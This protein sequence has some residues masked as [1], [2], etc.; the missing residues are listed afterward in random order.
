MTQGKMAAPSRIAPGIE[1]EDYYQAVRYKLLLIC[2]VGVCAYLNSL[3]GVFVLD[4]RSRIIDNPVIREL[5]RPAAV[6]LSPQRLVILS[7]Q[8]NYALTQFRPAGYHLF[9]VVVHI[10][11]A[12]AL[13]G[14]IC[15]TLLRSYVEP[16]AQQAAPWLALAAALLWMVHPL[17]T[18]AVTYVSQR[19]ELLAGLF[20]F[21]T[22]YAVIRGAEME[23][24]RSLWYAAAIVACI[25]GV[26]TIDRLMA[27]APILVF[28]YDRAYLSP[29]GSNPLKER[30]A[31]YAGLALSWVVL[32]IP[33]IVGAASVQL[34]TALAPAMNPL[35]YALTQP[36]VILH[37]LQLAFWPSSLCLDY[38]DW[39]VVGSLGEALPAMI[40]V[41]VLFAAAVLAYVRWPKV[42]FPALWFS[43]TL[44]PTFL[45]PSDG[46][47]ANESRMYVPLAGLVVLVAI[48]GFEV[49]LRL[50][51]AWPW[52][53]MAAGALVILIIAVFG[54]LTFRRN[55]EFRTELAIWQ[56]TVAKRPGNPR[57]HLYLGAAYH[58]DKKTDQAIAEYQKALEAPERPDNRV[59]RG[60]AV[61]NLARALLSEKR[62]DEALRAIVDTPI[63]GMDKAPSLS[64][65]G[66]VAW[67]GDDPA[68]AARLLSEAVHLDPKVPAY[69]FELA[70][71]LADSGRQEEARAEAKEGLRLDPEWPETA[72]AKAWQEATD[73]DPRQ[74]NP[75]DAMFRAR[76]ADVATGGRRPEMLD[77]LAAA[78][79]AGG[80]FSDAVATATKA[81]NLAATAKNTALAKEI[82]ERRAL[83]TINK[84]Y[85]RDMVNP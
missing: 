29:R 46:L 74:R 58:R 38:F 50:A 69:H 64:N 48:A 9:N 31:L 15:R 68:G 34:G 85:L 49:A 23:E 16:R 47:V 54:F 71:A 24:R 51:R 22:L 66:T 67:T 84:P 1:P 5:G 36:A 2:M 27:L 45:V 8:L 78:Y 30:P 13:F 10:L 44:A 56:D 42:G 57:A 72:R 73:P 41:V 11:S 7:L 19:G 77:T 39:P 65:F 55:A 37:Y 62:S 6:W 12:L 53:E 26:G 61:E 40:G 70:A 59:V 35:H 63:E 60:L 76:Q 14:I 25:L 82:T 3:Q 81:I 80:R 33:Y 43:L 75:R 18:Q 83:Y 32:A 20:L 52:A 21:A 17:Q 4:D 28:L 79:A